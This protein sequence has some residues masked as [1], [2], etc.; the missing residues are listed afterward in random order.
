MSASSRTLAAAGGLFLLIAASGSP[1]DPGQAASGQTTAPVAS[2]PQLVATVPRSEPGPLETRRIQGHLLNVERALRGRAPG[3]L[4]ARQRERR[5]A[6]LDWLR[7]YRERGTF[8][9]NH[10]YAGSRVPV[11]VDEHGTPCAV[12]YLLQRSGRGSLVS[13]IANAD[14]YV[15]AWELAGD[16]RFSEWLDEM[17]L[18]LEEAAR[19]Q[20][21]Y[22]PD[23]C[24]C[25]VDDASRT[26]R[27]V[28]PFT[29]GSLLAGHVVNGA[30]QPEAWERT[31][32]GAINGALAV[33]HAGFAANAFKEWDESSSGAEISLAANTALAVV[34]GYVAWTFLRS[35]SDGSETSRSGADAFSAMSMQRPRLLPPAAAWVG[36]GVGLQVRLIH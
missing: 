33:A 8:P 29:V 5:N 19:I 9:H 28:A 2:V 25:F 27:Y 20:P 30:T 10:T 13:E 36:G 32:V 34:S 11:F 6:A 4:S 23:G 15:Y 22:G 17:G 31:A 14:N 21:N 18:T 35:R 7:E 16:A 24:P 1:G 12:A 3:E 26:W